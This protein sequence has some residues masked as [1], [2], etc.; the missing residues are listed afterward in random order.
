MEGAK[1]RANPFDRLVILDPYEF[2]N[3]TFRSHLDEI[4]WQEQLLT[5]RIEESLYAG[6]HLT[7][8][9]KKDYTLATVRLPVS[10]ILYGFISFRF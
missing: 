2:R 3:K 5:K 1:S 7:F 8:C 6:Q 4:P 10:G 9:K